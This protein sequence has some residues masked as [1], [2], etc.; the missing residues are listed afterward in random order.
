MAETALEFQSSAKNAPEPGAMDGTGSIWDLEGPQKA[1]WPRSQCATQHWWDD[2]YN[3]FWMLLTFFWQLTITWRVCP[4]LSPF[5]IFLPKSRGSAP[6]TS[7]GTRIS[8][9]CGA[10]H[11]SR[12]ARWQVFGDRWE[13]LPGTS[14]V[15]C[16]LLK[17]WVLRY[18][19]QPSSNPVLFHWDRQDIYTVKGAPWQIV[20][21]SL[22][23]LL[24]PT[25]WLF[26]PK[27]SSNFKYI[28]HNFF[29]P[30][31]LSCLLRHLYK[32]G[33]Q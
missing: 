4:C 18:G 14:R 13:R 20:G 8:S 27:L 26:M 24:G 7:S 2:E 1:G 21:S 32:V 5:S 25:F 30:S 31:P 23:M 16:Q 17:L 29:L 12:V 9:W 28:D 33:S 19:M 6:A 11:R 15:K 3:Y 22:L 10:P